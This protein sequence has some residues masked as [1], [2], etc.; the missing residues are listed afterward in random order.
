MS[1][2]VK[3][4]PEFAKECKKIPQST[5]LSTKRYIESKLCFDPLRY[6]MM[7]KGTLRGHRRFRIGDYRIIF[8][9]EV[10]T[11]TL[12]IERISHRKEAYR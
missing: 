5:L 3:Y 10:D 1:Y 6:S 7:L 4:L 8:Y 2:D 11:Q 12:I 9:I